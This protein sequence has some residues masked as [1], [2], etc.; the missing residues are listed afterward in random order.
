MRAVMASIKPKHTANIVVGL[1]TVELRKTGPGTAPFKV[2]V[3]ETLDGGKGAGE[4]VCEFVCDK[5]MGTI[6]D[7][8]GR[9]RNEI[10]NAACLTEEEIIK[11]ARGGN[12]CGWHISNLEVYN[13]TIPLM[14]FKG[15][16]RTKFGLRPY[17]IKRPPQSWV[18]VEEL[19]QQP[20]EGE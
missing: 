7:V 3:Y 18:Y 17:A 11:Y 5:Y 4:V 1:K 8:Y 19:L 10:C 12:V 2:Y 20:A 15:L 13:E 9:V 16:Q 14:A 6:F